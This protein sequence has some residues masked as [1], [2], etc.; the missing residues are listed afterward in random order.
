MLLSKYGIIFK[1]KNMALDKKTLEELKQ[2][3]LAR[4]QKLEKGL[5]A[6][7][8]E[9]ERPGDYETRYN[10]IGTDKDENASE[11]EEYVDNLALEG[12]LEKQ[13]ADINRAL[14]KMKNGTYGICEKCG[15]EINIERLKIH[16]SA[17][18]CMKCNK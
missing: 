12:N 15:G 16:P 7:G 2:K 1:L 13:L 14:E 6:I 4:K 3:L 10:E 5:E 9:T 17:K 11:V 8:E 18:K